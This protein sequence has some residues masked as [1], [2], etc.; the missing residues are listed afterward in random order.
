M[1]D[2]ELLDLQLG[3]RGRM[4]ANR[5]YPAHSSMLSE[6]WVQDSR[7]LEFY[8][9][10]RELPFLVRFLFRSHDPENLRDVEV[11]ENPNGS[12]QLNL[13]ICGGKN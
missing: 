8:W 11:F 13:I 1:T 5:W 3:W 4:T 12:Y 2:E 7:Q 9:P 6:I 10:V